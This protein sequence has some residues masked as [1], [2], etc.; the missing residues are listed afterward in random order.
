MFGHLRIQS[1]RLEEQDRSLYHA[2]FCAVCHNLHGFAGWDASLLT[3]YDVTLWSLVAA[4]LVPEAANQRAQRRPCTAVPFRRVEVQPLG[5]QLGATLASLTILLA[6][7][8]LEDH[9]H[10]GGALLG[11]LGQ[12]WLGRR[13]RKARSYLLRQGYP[14]ASLLELPGR[15]LE[16]EQGCSGS[17]RM[18]PERDL[19]ALSAPTEA[20]IGDAFG[21]IAVLG[22]RP[23]LQP[24][25]RRL[26]QAIARYVY[27]W[28]ALQD[29]PRDR[30]S[31]D[32]N[33]LLAL[34][35]H[36]F[37]APP[38]R[39]GL[40]AALAVMREALTALG[41]ER[42][43]RKLCLDLVES[44]AGKVRQHPQLGRA[45]ATPAVSRRR[46]DQAGFVHSSDCDCCDANCCDSGCDGCNLCEINCCDCQPGDACFEIDCLDCL[47][48]WGCGCVPDCCDDVACCCLTDRMLGKRRQRRR[49][50]DGET[51]PS[52][53]P[54]P[55]RRCPHCGS[56]VRAPRD[57]SHPQSC[58]ACRR[59]LP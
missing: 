2:H 11:R 15:Q 27:L 4:G 35:G 47:D 9:R 44:L 56:R 48:C 46:L 31:G 36:R 29:L 52:S 30:R 13:E 32:F 40:E 24:E 59:E 3:N 8:K 38:L 20:A 19:L 26:G 49:R 33:A 50:K 39:A 55:H 18:R 34:W 16:V 25:L 23:A 58:P 51:A 10:D 43:R 6:W 41:L 45:A 17:G 5:V 14:L 28:D 1:C 42:G 7:A 12:A 54:A 21:W 22:H 37:P 57:G 53:E